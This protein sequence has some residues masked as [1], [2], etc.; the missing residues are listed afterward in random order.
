[1]PTNTTDQEV[2]EEFYKQ[3]Q[4]LLERTPNRDTTIVLGD[5]NA[6]VGNDNSTRKIMMGK[7]GL[8]TMNDK[9]G[10]FFTDFCEQTDLVI[11]G[12]VLPP[13]TIHKVTWSSLYLRTE[14]QIDHFTPAGGQEP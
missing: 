11:F 2:K 12:T 13:C 10:E 6:K 14:N 3:S 5:F 8:G 1:V 9:Y 4:S 7:E